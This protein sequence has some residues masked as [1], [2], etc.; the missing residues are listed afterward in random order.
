[1]HS[2]FGG[3]TVN[4][5]QGI[6]VVEGAD[7]TDTDC[8]S[9]RRGAIGTDVHAGDTALEGF[10]GVVLILLCKVFGVHCGDGTGK[11]GLALDGVTSDHN[12]LKHLGI[13]I[14]DNLHMLCGGHF[15]SDIT[16]G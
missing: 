11:V 6:I 14:K 2:G 3:N 15:N 16:D 1:M 9:T 8:C 13:L 12:L 5:V 10:Y 7:T 4:D